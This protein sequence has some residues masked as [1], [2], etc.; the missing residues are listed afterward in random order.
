MMALQEHASSGAAMSAATVTVTLIVAR[1]RGCEVK[2]AALLD[3]FGFIVEPVTEVRARA[4]ADA[5]S[6]YGKGWHAASLNF[7]DCFAYALARELA[8]PLLFIG[9]DFPLTDIRAVL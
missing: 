5:Y 7:G 2:I 8:C 3:G 1:G 9:D 4:A 6:R